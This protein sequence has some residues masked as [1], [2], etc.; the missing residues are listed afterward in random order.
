MKQPSRIE[1]SSG[2]QNNLIVRIKQNDAISDPDKQILTGLIE[3]NGWLQHTLQ[4]KN[5]SINRLKNL[6]FGNSSEHGKRKKKKKKS[7][8]GDLGL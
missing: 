8:G 3:F 4:E 2:D 5:I 7:G 1:M 6:Y